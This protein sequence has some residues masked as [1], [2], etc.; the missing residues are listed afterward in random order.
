MDTTGQT[1]TAAGTDYTLTDAGTVTL[2]GTEY[3]V[4]VQSYTTTGG[5]TVWLHGPRDAVYFL[6]A[7]QERGG[8][9]GLRQVISWKSGAELRRQGNEVRVTYVAGVLE[10]YVPGRR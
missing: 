3:R 1:D 9:T 5:E 10:E 7:Y 4:E 8:D 2:R 6:R